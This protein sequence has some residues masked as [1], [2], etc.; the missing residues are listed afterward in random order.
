MDRIEIKASAR[1][2]IEGN[3]LKFVAI[4]AIIYLI[5]FGLSYI[6]GSLNVRMMMSGV[7][8]VRLETTSFLTSI[9]IT[10]LLAPFELSLA[11]IFVDVSNG[12]A[13]KVRDT[14]WGFNYT[15]KSIIAVLRVFVFTALWS[16]LL[17]IPGI[18]KGYSYMMTMYI[19][20]DEPELS[21][22]EA[23]QKSMYL[24]D[25]HKMELFVLQLSFIGWMLLS[26]LTFGLLLV[27]VIP[28]MEAATANFYQSIKREA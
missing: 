4:F 18:I 26:S 27:Y 21:A 16:L 1:K 14:F 24:M 13:P 15:I 2:Q 17:I 3:I 23:M 9:A 10:A 12:I 8:H 22:K 7:S 5:A 28:Y 6:D 20:A 19:L 11:K 25:G